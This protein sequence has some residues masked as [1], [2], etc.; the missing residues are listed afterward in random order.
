MK[1]KSL[2]NYFAALDLGTNSFHLIIVKVNEDYTLNVIDKE[3]EVIRLGSEHGAGMNFISDNEI[4][5]AINVLNN[6]KKLAGNYKAK[7][8]AVATSAVRE[9]ENKNDFIEKVLIETGINIEIIDGYEEA[10][11]IYFGAEK[12]LSLKNKKV[13]CIDIGG[14]STEFILSDKG[15][16]IFAESIKIGAVRLTKKFFPDFV[17]NNE[18]IKECNNFIEKEILSNKNINLNE[19]FD[20][21]VGSSGTIE[22][23]A[24]MI[25]FRKQNKF[26]DQINGFVF[27]YNDLKELI[28]NILNKKTANERLQVKGMETKRADIIPAGLLILNKVFELFNLKNI[29]VSDYALREGIIFDM[30]N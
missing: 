13:L 18:R 16:I 14:G 21:A 26:P 27:D 10:K 1:K 20:L 15:N 23:A 3:R 25:N 8:R 29:K 6:F 12:A 5:K 2:D 19:N 17:I 28:E 7:M 30:I 9:A 4:E 22:A 11:L 24:I